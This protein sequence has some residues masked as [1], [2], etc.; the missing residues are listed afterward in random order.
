MRLDYHSSRQ[1]SALAGRSANAFQT[2]GG[3]LSADTLQL[4]RGSDGDVPFVM[5]TERLVGYE[6][7]VGRWTEAQHRAALRDGRHAY[8]IAWWESQTVGFAIVRDWASSERLAH[9]KRIAVCRSGRGHG[10]ALLASLVDVIFRDTE[11]HRIWLGVYPENE[12]ARRAYEAVGFQIEGI[13]RGG[14]FFGGT[15]RDELI[16]SLLRPE[17]SSQGPLGG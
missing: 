14:S 11:A 10:R 13:A 15:Y 9:I 4:T 3:A 6:H 17:W 1:N 16:M 12:R 2:D 7:L 8:F 5:A